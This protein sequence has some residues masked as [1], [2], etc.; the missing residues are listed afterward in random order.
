MSISSGRS[1]ALGNLSTQSNLTLSKKTGIVYDVILNGSHPF[2]VKKRV[3]SLY[4]GCIL[5]RTVDNILPARTPKLDLT[6]YFQLTASPN[7]YSK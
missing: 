6:T 4:I 2:A 1:T 5:F 7:E 3:G